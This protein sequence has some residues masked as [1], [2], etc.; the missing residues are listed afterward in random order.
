MEILTLVGRLP[1]GR[2]VQGGFENNIHNLIKY[3]H[4]FQKANGVQTN[5]GHN[6]SVLGFVPDYMC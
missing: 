5:T 2:R 6:L 4:N 3:R 1:Q